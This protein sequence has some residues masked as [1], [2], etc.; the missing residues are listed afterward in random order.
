MVV[1]AYWLAHARKLARVRAFEYNE[2]YTYNAA[3]S[4]RHERAGAP[5]GEGAIWWRWR[6]ME[7]YVLGKGGGAAADPMAMG[8]GS[9]G[10]SFYKQISHLI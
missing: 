10:I 8:V 3:A 7:R 6:I 9:P 5:L 2:C 4:R 1:V